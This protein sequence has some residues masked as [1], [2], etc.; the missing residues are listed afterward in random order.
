MPVRVKAVSD[1]QGDRFER[2][3]AAY[4][5]RAAAA[6]VLVPLVSLLLL[7]VPVRVQLRVRGAGDG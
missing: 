1:E 4:E 6:K 2:L 3:V 5:R 7:P